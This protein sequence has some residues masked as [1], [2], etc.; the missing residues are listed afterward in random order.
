LE[1]GLAIAFTETEPDSFRH[2]QNLVLY[3]SDNADQVEDEFG[4]H[5]GLKKR[6]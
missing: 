3:N 2:L 5:L 6:S 1:D 4:A